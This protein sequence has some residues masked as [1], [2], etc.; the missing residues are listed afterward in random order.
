MNTPLYD[1][2]R[3]KI[4]VRPMPIPPIYQPGTVADVI[5]HAAEHPARDLVAGGAAKGF[6]LGQRLAPRLLDAALV[7]IGFRTQRTGEEKDEGSASNLFAPVSGM[8]SSE[9]PF[10][11]G[12]WTHSAYNWLELH[13]PLRALASLAS[14][15]PRLRD[16]SEPATGSWSSGNG[17]P[18]AADPRGAERPSAS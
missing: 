16:K 18:R 9:G 1:K 17:Q 14:G 3:T 12:A 15:P 6:L 13:S 4:G 8:S 2:A 10:G 11:D 5:L 7:R